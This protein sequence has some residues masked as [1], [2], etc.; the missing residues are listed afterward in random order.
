SMADLALAP[1]SRWVRDLFAGI[2]FSAIPLLCCGIWFIAFHIY[3]LRHSFAWTA[4]G[5][6]VAASIAV[7]AIEETFFRRVVLGVLLSTGRQYMSLFA[8]VCVCST[9]H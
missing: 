2:L 6:I 7:P 3:S 8:T 5:K 9:I 1:D 4:F